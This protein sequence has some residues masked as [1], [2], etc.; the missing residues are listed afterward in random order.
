MI[1]CKYIILIAVLLF[2]IYMDKSIHSCKSE[3]AKVIILIHHVLSVYIYLGTLMLP[4]H[5]EHTVVAITSILFQ[6]LYG[7]CPITKI[8]NNMCEFPE[9]RRMPT[10]FDIFFEKNTSRV[11]TYSLV[12]YAIINS[13]RQPTLKTLVDRSQIQ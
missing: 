3:S 5:V 9:Y 8:T 2:Q 4:Y 13:L 7:M 1:D 11:I 10:I 12:I 6:L